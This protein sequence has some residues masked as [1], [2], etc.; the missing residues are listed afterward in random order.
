MTV[1]R[2]CFFCVTSLVLAAGPPEVVYED[3]RWRSIGPLR[4]GR[5]VAVAGSPTDSNIF[6]VSDG[7]FKTGCI[8]GNVS[9]GVPAHT[10]KK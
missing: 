2:T 10:V 1:P 3:L 6:Y 9:H 7:F 8:D 4:G 5:V